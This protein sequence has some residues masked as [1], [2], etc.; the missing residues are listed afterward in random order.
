MFAWNL[1]T[2]CSRDDR[3]DESGRKIED[4]TEIW[5]KILGMVNK[6]GH[7]RDFKIHALICN[8]KYCNVRRNSS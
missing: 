2:I 7:K 5:M 6:E 4:L 3:W 8:E 1:L